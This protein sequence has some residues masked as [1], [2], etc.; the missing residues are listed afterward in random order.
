MLATLYVSDVKIW[1][2]MFT[3]WKAQKEKVAPVKGRDGLCYL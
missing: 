1:K 3:M 2:P